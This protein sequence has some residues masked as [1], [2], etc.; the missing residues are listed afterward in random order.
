M[1]V[2]IYYLADAK[3]EIIDVVFADVNDYPGR[4][5]IYSGILALL[6]AIGLYL[7]SKTFA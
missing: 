3:G 7:E 1:E 6:I 5:K 4:N 2:D